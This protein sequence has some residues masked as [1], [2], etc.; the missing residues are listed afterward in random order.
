MTDLCSVL[1]NT[2]FQTLSFSLETHTYSLYRSLS[3]LRSPFMKYWIKRSQPK[4]GT[5]LKKQTKAHTH[6]SFCSHCHPALSLFSLWLDVLWYV[7]GGKAY[8]R[9][10]WACLLVFACA[11]YCKIPSLLRIIQTS[12]LTKQV[13]CTSHLHAGSRTSSECQAGNIGVIQGYRCNQCLTLLSKL[14][15]LAQLLS[16]EELI[17]TPGMWQQW[18]WC[19][20]TSSFSVC[21]KKR[22]Y[23]DQFN[24]L[25]YP[26]VSVYICKCECIWM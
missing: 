5:Q 8:K 25:R 26:F 14:W 15:R 3:T 4:Q 24:L 12:Q 21:V 17:H 7:Y 23:T 9:L 10:S 20:Y 22:G 13:W 11:L 19:V 2:T 1:M 6:V 18:L 16:V